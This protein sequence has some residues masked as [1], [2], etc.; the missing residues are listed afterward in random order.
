[1]EFIQ[2]ISESV[3]ILMIKGVK[4]DAEHEFME[5]RRISR[6]TMLL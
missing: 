4:M 5:E 3:V 2:N 1:M 6:G